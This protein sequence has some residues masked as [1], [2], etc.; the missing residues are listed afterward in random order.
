[1]NQFDSD[2]M[3][4]L[5]KLAL[6][7]G[8][9]TTPEAALA[10]FQQYRV[11]IHLGTGWAD[12]LAG[13]ACFVTALSTA[14]RAFLGRVEV[15][16]DLAPLLRLPLFA[17]LPT[18]QVVQ[19]L[20]GTVVDAPTPHVPSLLIGDGAVPSSA[21]FAIRPTWDGWCAQ[22]APV[23]SGGHLTTSDNNPLSGVC[24]GA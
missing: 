11:R 20:G 1:M 3:H 8:E 24:A 5:A 9:A 2:S 22:I 6:D 19:Q 15:D 4:R 12:T 13:Q 23:G 21:T 14:S 7:A 16:G 17:G 18:A 10:L